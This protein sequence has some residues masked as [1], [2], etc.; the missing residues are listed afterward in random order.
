MIIYGEQPTKSMSHYL[1]KLSTSFLFCFSLEHWNVNNE[2]LHGDFFEKK[3]GDANITM[4]MF[5]DVH[6]TEPTVK[7]FLNDYGIME[8]RGCQKAIVCIQQLSIRLS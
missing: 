3:T 6:A 5:E 8:A 7:L 4:K 2:N 1:S